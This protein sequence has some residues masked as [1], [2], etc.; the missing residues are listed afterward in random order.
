MKLGDP[1][2]NPLT[3]AYSF[4]F[5]LFAQSSGGSALFSEDG[6]HCGPR[7]VRVYYCL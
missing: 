6:G 2:G 7:E 5:K 3:G 1:S 4:R